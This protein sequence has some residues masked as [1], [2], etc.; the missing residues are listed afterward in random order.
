MRGVE[1]RALKG[2]RSLSQGV[3]DKCWCGNKEGQP[4]QFR[5]VAS[6]GGFWGETDF[7]SH[8]EFIRTNSVMTSS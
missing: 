1:E 2:V 5:G 8:L 4:R 3:S 6:G 7:R